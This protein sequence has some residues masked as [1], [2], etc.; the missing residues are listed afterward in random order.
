MSPE[1]GTRSEVLARLVPG[2]GVPPAALAAEIDGLA[3]ALVAPP[4]AV[5][6][7]EGSP[8]TGMLLLEAG[9]VRVSRADASGREL[10][11][12]RVLPRET[13]VLTLSC[14]LGSESY[15][16]RGV[17]DGEVRGL[18]LP[19]GVFE[20]LLAHSPAF[21]TF[22][23]S[24]FAARLRGVLELASAVTFERLDRRLAV[25]LLARVESSG[26]IELAV[27]H[28][29]LADELGCAREPV[30]RLLEGFEQR[31]LLEL[32]RG[33]VRVLDKAALAGRPGERA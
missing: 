21:R 12:Y 17:A 13:C 30:S 6:F 11:L 19:A 1:P 2:L 16:A 18:F 3:A 33:R 31:G 27:T 5:L 26:R 15:P 8:C 29:Q 28:Q 10:L 4:G 23:F 14:L 22:V 20:K 9:V 32:G 7:D 25:A 24:S